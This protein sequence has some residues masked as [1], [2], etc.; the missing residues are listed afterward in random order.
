MRRSRFCRIAADLR[1]PPI[2]PFDQ[3]NC[4]QFKQL[5]AVLDRQYDQSKVALLLPSLV[6]A[7]RFHAPHNRKKRRE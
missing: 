3:Q 5:S 2:L 7:G 1:R 4:C 6:P